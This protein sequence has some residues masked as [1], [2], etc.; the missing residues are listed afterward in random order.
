MKKRAN[1]T[2]TVVSNLDKAMRK[3]KKAVE[4]EGI[5]RDIKKRMYFESKTQ[6]RRKSKMRAI[7]QEILRKISRELS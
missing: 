5:V 7:K 6:R 4:K 3:F 2:V 1:I